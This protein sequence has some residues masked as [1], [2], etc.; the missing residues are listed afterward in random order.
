MKQ[1]QHLGPVLYSTSPGGCR[2]VL[3]T[4]LSVYTA[5]HNHPSSAVTVSKPRHP[6]DPWSLYALVQSWKISPPPSLL[7]SPPPLPLPLPSAPT[8][9]HPAT[10]HTL[11]QPPPPPILTMQL[12]P[13]P[14]HLTAFRGPCT[15]RP[16]VCAGRRRQYTV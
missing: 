2:Q 5:D 3:V 16:I 10:F 4:S 12:S 7:P 11:P 6:L 8:P 14:C 13:L 9:L 1:Y 15:Q